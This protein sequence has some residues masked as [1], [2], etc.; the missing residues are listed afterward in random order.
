MGY[1]T[2]QDLVPLMPEAELLQLADDSADRSGT[3][4]SPAVL[5][6]L[7][8]AIDQACR[9]ID[10]F[11]STA[12]SGPAVPLDPVPPLA[13]NLAARGAVYNLLLRRRVKIEAWETDHDR[14]MRLLE[15]IAKGGV[16]LGAPAAGEQAPADPQGGVEVAAPARRFDSAT[17]RRF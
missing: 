8:E 13:A 2:P 5:A 6:V 10:A 1:C 12:P 16:K 9:E 7:A 4:E 15:S 14:C 17:W 11:V 3:L